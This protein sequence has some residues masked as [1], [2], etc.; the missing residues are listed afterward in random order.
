MYLAEDSILS[1]GILTQPK[2]Q[3]TLK[4]VP[5]A[6]ASTDPVDNLE[7]FLG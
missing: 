4:F 1:L 7:D 6:C 2:K 3:Y 5:D